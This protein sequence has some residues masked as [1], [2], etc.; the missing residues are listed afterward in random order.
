MPKPY[1][2]VELRHLRAFVAVAEDLGFRRAAERLHIA[3][4]ALSRAIMEIEAALG[5]RLF[6]R[7]TRMVRLTP[8]AQFLLPEV[9]T[10]FQRLD[11]TLARVQ[12]IDRGEAGMLNVGFNDFTISDLLPTI[13]MRFRSVYP[14]ISV[15]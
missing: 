13:I 7:S 3:Q 2:S 14:D 4:P 15:H 8:A 12:R 1:Q 10:L 6:E 5:V 11:E 9:R